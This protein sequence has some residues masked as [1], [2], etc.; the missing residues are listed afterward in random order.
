MDSRTAQRL[1]IVLAGV[2]LLSGCFGDP[3][4]D[5]E[6]QPLEIIAGNPDPELGPCLLNVDEVGAGTHDVTPIALASK[7]RVRILDPSGA[8]V[9]ERAIESHPGEG[10]AHE[11]L[12]QDRGSVRLGAGDHHVEC[13]LEAGTYSATLRVVPARPGYED[14]GTD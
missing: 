12:S 3:P 7:A 14:N 4:P 11:V 8:V 13:I 6:V 1:C 5:A 10:G 9:F 2:G